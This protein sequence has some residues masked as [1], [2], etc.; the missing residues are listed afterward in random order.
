MSGTITKFISSK[1][2]NFVFAPTSE[3][4]WVIM[5][6][7]FAS[8]GRLEMHS[9][10][11]FVTGNICIAARMGSALFVSNRMELVTTGSAPRMR[12]SWLM[13]S[14][15]ADQAKSTGIDTMKLRRRVTLYPSS[16]L[17]RRIEQE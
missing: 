4:I 12:P 11:G 3:L 8:T 13:R 1:S 2:F 5:A 6:S 9:F 10:H 7:E 16:Y 14:A 17:F 15:H